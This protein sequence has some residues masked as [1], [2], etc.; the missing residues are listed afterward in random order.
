M[1]KNGSGFLRWFCLVFIILGMSGM[2]SAESINLV[3]QVV[4]PDSK[5]GLSVYL[6]GNFQG[7]NPGDSNYQLDDLGN[8]LYEISRS[9]EVGQTIQFKFTQGSWETV[10]KGPGGE[11]ISNRVMR[12]EKSG[13]HNLKVAAWADGQPG[14]G[15]VTTITGDVKP[16]RVPNFLNE[17]EVL[18][19]L[20]PQYH[21]NPQV[22]Y[23]VLY[24]LDGQNVFDAATSFAGEWSADESCEQLI[25]EGKIRPLIVVAI[26]NG[27]DQRIYE[28]TPWPD[29]T[30]TN[31][32]SGGGE[33]HIQAIVD[34]LLPYINS[35]YRTLTGPENTGLAGSSLGGLMALYAAGNH[36]YTFGLLAAFSPSLWWKD[37][38]PLTFARQNIIPGLKLYLDMGGR[39]GNLGKNSGT[40]S[41]HVIQRL[42]KMLENGGFVNEK[43]LMVVKDADGEHNES[44][45]ARRLPSALV[46]LF[47][48][49][50]VDN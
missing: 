50:E 48:P 19:Y 21:Q 46:F 43:D 31:A 17:R 39:E 30:Y 37:G 24:M 33:Q 10:E 49:A 7:W 29:S 26:A 32:P 3:F 36:Q 22:R 45:W 20:P 9:F 13:I 41:L 27:R 25:S 14:T 38:F 15:I 18:V 23:P 2:A 34:T 11:E 6:A 44:S 40:Y 4:E 5:P 35:T 47:S 8:G 42:K 28:Y 12:I 16:V 1:T